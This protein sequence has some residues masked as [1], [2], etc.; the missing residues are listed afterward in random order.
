MSILRKL[1]KSGMFGL[2]G[3]AATN[4][5]AVNKIAGSGGL[6]VMGMLLAKKKRAQER[7]AGAM[8]GRPMAEEPMVSVDPA[9]PMMRK[10]GAVKK[11]VKGGKLTDLTGDGK[12]TRA[13]VLKGRGVKGFSN[14]GMP[15]IEESI[16]SGNRVSRQVGEET[17]RMMPP[18]KRTM[19]SPGES[20]KSGN[21]I[22]R[23]EGAEMRKMR[24]AKGGV[25]RADGCAV[26]GK[27]KGKMV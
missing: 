4:K 11:M 23:Q 26:R 20:V 7:A 3:L 14:G 13:D 10:G 15:S 5:D 6:G 19:P 21:R 18:K 2:A 27:T 9:G 17:K 22:A 1:G 24:M 25:T 8:P 16:K 12:V